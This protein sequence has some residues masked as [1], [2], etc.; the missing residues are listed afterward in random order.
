MTDAKRAATF[1]AV[2]HRPESRRN[3]REHWAASMKTA[4][5]LAPQVAGTAW[6]GAESVRDSYSRT[7]KG[8]GDAGAYWQAPPGVIS[9]RLLMALEALSE[10][11]RAR[12]RPE[13]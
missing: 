13:K 1:L 10:Q 9:T 7:L 5:K 4:A 12:L 11:Q 3:R 8:L 6:A 2:R